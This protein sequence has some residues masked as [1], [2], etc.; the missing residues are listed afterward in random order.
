MNFIE[1]QV[2]FMVFALIFDGWFFLFNFD[3]LLNLLRFYL[4]DAKIFVDF[5]L[6]VLIVVRSVGFFLG[7][8]V[9]RF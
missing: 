4:F 8:F 9:E 5:V 2:C 1:V 3:L 6:F 7:F